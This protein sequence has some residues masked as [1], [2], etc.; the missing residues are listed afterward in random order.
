MNGHAVVTLGFTRP[1]Y[2]HE[3]R[4]GD[5]FAFPDAPSTPLTVAH[6]KKTGLSADLTLLNLTVHGRDEPLHLPA[7]TPVKALRMLRTVSLACLLCRKSQDID[8]DLPHDGEP[9][10][11]VCAD[12]VPDLDE[13]TENE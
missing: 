12:H 10:S 3:L 2:A 4:P 6:V 5:V 7:N 8:L 11:L 13:L 9:L 1:V